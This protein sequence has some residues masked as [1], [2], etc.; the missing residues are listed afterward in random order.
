MKVIE[1]ASVPIIA[2]YIPIFRNTVLLKKYGEAK[3]KYR[4]RENR[5]VDT[6]MR[7]DA[8]PLLNLLRSALNRVLVVF[9]I[10]HPP[11]AYLRTDSCVASE[12]VRNPLMDPPYITMILSDIVSNSGISEVIIMTHF[13]F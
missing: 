4:M 3:E 12:E 10:Y 13:P 1:Q 2:A 7:E 11:I 9:S 6:V 8:S 5:A